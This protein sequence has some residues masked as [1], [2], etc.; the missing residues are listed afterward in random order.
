MIVSVPCAP[1]MKVSKMDGLPRQAQS[2]GTF[3]TAFP[4]SLRD[5][6]INLSER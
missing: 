3:L 2:D 6:Q 4:F 1:A 5:P